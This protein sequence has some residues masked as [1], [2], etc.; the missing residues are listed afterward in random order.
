MT[1]FYH[2]HLCKGSVSKC[3]HIQGGEGPNIRTLGDTIQPITLP[4][5]QI[6]NAELGV[7][8]TKASC[9]TEDT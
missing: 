5:V 6:C 1:S 9:D 8:R 4:Y 3:S 7:Y 2:A